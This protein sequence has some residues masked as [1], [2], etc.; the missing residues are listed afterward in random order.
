MDSGYYAAC[1]ALIA[2]S[3]SLDVIANNLSNTS[4][5]GYRTEHSQ[6]R[7]VLANAT[8]RPMSTLNRAT[9]DYGVLGGSRVD[10]SQG[11]LER[12]GND[13]DF[14]IE[15]SGFFVVQTAN[16]RFFTRNGSFHLAHGQLVTADGNPVMGDSGVIPIANGTI[17]VSTDGTIS[18]NG[19]VAGKIKLVDFK[20]GTA[21]E[22]VGNTYYSAPKDSEIPADGSQIHQGM[23]EDSNVNPVENAVELITVQRTADLAQRALS[24]F[25]SQ[26]NKIAADDLPRVNS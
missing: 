12:T 14:G 18:V 3:Q 1:T 10:L 6:F 19:A 16:G 2:Q 17:S 26:F 20:P 13:L 21:L 25:D 24:L 8:N 22:S 23:V 5:S 15:G 7:S 9:N 4:T 11:S